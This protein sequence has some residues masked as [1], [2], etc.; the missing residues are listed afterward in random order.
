MESV[1]LSPEQ[2]NQFLAREVA[3][4]QK[5]VADLRLEKQP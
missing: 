2:F 5:I 3:Q 1:D 4:N